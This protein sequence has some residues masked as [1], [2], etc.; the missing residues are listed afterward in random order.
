MWVALLLALNEAGQ[1][2]PPFGP[3]V[4]TRRDAAPT[5]VMSMSL[6]KTCAA[7]ENSAAQHLRAYLATRMDPGQGHTNDSSLRIVATW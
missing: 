3:R 1:T 6:T 2:T 7:C 4:T 5:C